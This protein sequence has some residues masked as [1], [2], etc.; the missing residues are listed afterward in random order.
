MGG[1]PATYCG[2]E[3]IRI[4][5]NWA[6]RFWRDFWNIT[7][8]IEREERIES[9]AGCP[10]FSERFSMKLCSRLALACIAASSTAELYAEGALKSGGIEVLLLAPVVWAVLSRRSHP[11]LLN[12][13][14]S[15]IGVV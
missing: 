8:R 14:L 3:T 9:E 5:E 2:G 10:S 12:L 13:L 15:L 1:Q 6:M 4:W 7:C 11:V